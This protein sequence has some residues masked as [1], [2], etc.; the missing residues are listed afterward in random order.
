MGCGCDVCV[1]VWCVMCVVCVY[2]CVHG[3][4]HLCDRMSVYNGDLRSNCTFPPPLLP[5]PST[6]TYGEVRMLQEQ[7]YDG[8]TQEA[9]LQ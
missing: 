2:V 8:E 4:M 5:C 1:Y 3:C 7:A 9:M 6:A